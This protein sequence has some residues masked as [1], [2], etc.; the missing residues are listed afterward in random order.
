MTGLHGHRE[1]LVHVSSRSTTDPLCEFSHATRRLNFRPL[2]QV[3]TDWKLHVNLIV[4]FSTETTHKAPG[5]HPFDLAFKIALSDSQKSCR[6]SAGP[7][8]VVSVPSAGIHRMCT[9][10]WIDGETLVCAS[11]MSLGSS[12]PSGK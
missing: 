7:V 1:S 4:S 3:G 6:V 10:D 9:P 8:L 5:G 11:D 2:Y 12:F